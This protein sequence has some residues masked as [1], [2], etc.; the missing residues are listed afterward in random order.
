MEKGPSDFNPY[1]PPSSLADAP[2][3][4]PTFHG[5]EVPLATL[6]QRFLGAFIDN[7]LAFF[8][9]GSAGF[10]AGVLSAATQSGSQDANEILMLALIGVGAIAYMVLQS[11]LITRTGQSLGKRMVKT[12]IVLQDGRLPGFWRGV[13]L[14]SWLTASLGFIPLFGSVIGLIDLFM[15][16]RT[17]RRMLHDHIAG[18][19]VIQA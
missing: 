16:F 14:R 5:H 15:V 7:M 13:V 1:A 11:V 9:L 3:G 10:V 4:E 8:L 18:T 17:D 12:R 19:S 6:G 2:I